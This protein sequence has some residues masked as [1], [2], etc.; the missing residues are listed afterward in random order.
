MTELVP[1][2]PA[3]VA[4]KNIYDID[5]LDLFYQEFLLRRDRAAEDTKWIKAFQA[6]LDRIADGADHF[7]LRGNVVATYKRNG[8]LN[9]TR[10][11]EE[12]PEVIKQYTRLVTK[13]DFDKDAFEA[14]EPELFAEYRAKVF[15]V[16]PKQGSV[17]F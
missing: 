12:H 6:Q 3:E 10:L 11:E 9:L 4:E 13:L 16:V 7:R 1:R 5:D 2:T 14:Q 8:N 17:N 15:R